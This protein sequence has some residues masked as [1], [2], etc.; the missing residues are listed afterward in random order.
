VPTGGDRLATI[1]IVGPNPAARSAS[2]KSSHASRAIDVVAIAPSG[3]HTGVTAIGVTRAQRWRSR[4]G[5]SPA[6]KQ[7]GASYLPRK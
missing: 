3:R 2:P 4:C 5:C 6:K 7:V 1:W